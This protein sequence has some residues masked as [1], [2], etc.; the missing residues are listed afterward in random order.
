MAS[1][2]Q[3]SPPQDMLRRFKF[4]AENGRQNKARALALLLLLVGAMT[5]S[6]RAEDRH[7][8]V[9][10]LQLQV[11]VVPT[12]VALQQAHRQE[13]QPSQS[14]VTFNLTPDAKQSS[15]VSM[16]SMSTVEQGNSN[17]TAVLKTLTIVSE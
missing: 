7:T 9:A 3:L 8:A 6:L 4:G 1:P 15:N 17:R 14:A 10:R 2:V 12:V 13:P 16:Q 11:T 5:P